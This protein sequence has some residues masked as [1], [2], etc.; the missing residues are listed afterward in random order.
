MKSSQQLAHEEIMALFGRKPQ[1]GTTRT[2]LTYARR[3]TVGITVAPER[4]HKQSW[5]AFLEIPLHAY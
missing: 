3:V 1:S 4:G 5:L 2:R